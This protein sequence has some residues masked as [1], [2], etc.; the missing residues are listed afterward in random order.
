MSLIEYIKR[1][2]WYNCPANGRKT[3]NDNCFKG[4]RQKSK[5]VYH[6]CE[7]I[8]VSAVFW[9]LG[10]FS[11]RSAGNVTNKILR[12]PR[13]A[14]EIG[15]RNVGALQLKTLKHLYLQSLKKK[16]SPCW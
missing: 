2:E 9:K 1:L 7:Q 11:A 16:F 13:R 14:S 12:N 6:I 3:L 8:E 4:K 15:A 10:D 5:R